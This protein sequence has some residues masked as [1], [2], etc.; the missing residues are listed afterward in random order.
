MNDTEHRILVEES[1]SLKEDFIIK[2]I[3]DKIKLYDPFIES[4][5]IDLKIMINLQRRLIDAN[6]KLNEIKKSNNYEDEKFLVAVKTIIEY[7]KKCE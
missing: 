6:N 7:I 1:D 2:T 4:N 5:S 3:S